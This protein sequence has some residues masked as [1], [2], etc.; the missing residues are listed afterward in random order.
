MTPAGAFAPYQQRLGGYG[1]SFRRLDRPSQR[2]GFPVPAAI[3]GLPGIAPIQPTQRT[4]F[5]VAVTCSVEGGEATRQRLGLEPLARRLDF[6]SG[7][8]S[9]VARIT[10]RGLWVPPLAALRRAPRLQVIPSTEKEHGPQK[11]TR[12]DASR[13]GSLERLSPPKMN[14]HCLA[15]STA[16]QSHSSPRV[17]L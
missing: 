5:R 10:P 8:P 16:Q 12:P 6:N 14:C 15:S 2:A 1:P 11:K 17:K 13:S 9:D 7:K 4:S 3:C